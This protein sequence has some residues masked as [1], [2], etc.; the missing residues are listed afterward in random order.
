MRDLVETMTG[1]DATSAEV[2]IEPELDGLEVAVKKAKVAAERAARDQI[3]AAR[4]A[5]RVA[6]ALREKGLSVS[7]RSE[8]LRSWLPSR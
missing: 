4:D 1:Q 8:N 6:R 5:R 3:Q 7:C 2:V